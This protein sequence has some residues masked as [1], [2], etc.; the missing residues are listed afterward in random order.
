M[1]SNDPFPIDYETIREFAN[2]NAGQK[3][4]KMVQ[5]QS[6]SQMK[7]AL[8]QAEE[9]N[10]AQAQQILKQIFSDAEITKLMQEMED[11]HERNG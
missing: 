2:T 3:L 9:G 7:D 4:I 1:K 10:Y 11:E 8:K 6:G 5:R